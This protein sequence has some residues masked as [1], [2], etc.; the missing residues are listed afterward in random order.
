MGKNRVRKKMGLLYDRLIVQPDP[1][2]SAY[3]MMVR[4]LLNEAATEFPHK[5]SYDCGDTKYE[6]WYD[7]WFSQLVLHKKPLYERDID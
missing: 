7:K 3:Y 5:S 2:H 1:K 4:R 6:E